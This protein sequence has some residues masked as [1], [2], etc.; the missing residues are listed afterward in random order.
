[1]SWDFSMVMDT[2]GPELVCVEGGLNYTYNVSPM[3]YDAIPLKDGIGG[4]DG[5]RAR[6]VI[7]A[8]R[9]GLS[10]MQDN[11]DRYIPMNPENGWGDY[12]G[13]MRL[14]ESLIRWAAKHPE[15]RFEV[16]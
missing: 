3:F 8:L 2:G 7:E 16:S 10:K 9:S 13:A 6:D 5:E 4:I 11:P 14:L 1:M 12:E 15:A